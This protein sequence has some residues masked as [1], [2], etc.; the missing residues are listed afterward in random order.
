MSAKGQKRTSRG[1]WLDHADEQRA[2]H[3]E[4]SR[5]LQEAYA[6]HQVR[7]SRRIFLRNVARS[8]MGAK[9]YEQARRIRNKIEMLFAH[10]KRIMN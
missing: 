4:K 3:V 8:L 2:L 7:R 5:A 9:L 6:A 1:P 10:L